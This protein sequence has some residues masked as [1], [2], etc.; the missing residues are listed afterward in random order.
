MVSNVKKCQACMYSHPGNDQDVAEL[1]VV[2]A[3]ASSFVDDIQNKGS[4]EEDD[5]KG[6]HGRVERMSRD[7]GLGRHGCFV[8]CGCCVVYMFM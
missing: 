6:N 4:N 8:F 5:G 1:A 7:V 3:R 2:C